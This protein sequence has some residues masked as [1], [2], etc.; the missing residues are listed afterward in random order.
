[1]VAVGAL[2][3]FAIPGRGR[4]DEVSVMTDQAVAEAA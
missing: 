3:A 4:R 1:V 2:A